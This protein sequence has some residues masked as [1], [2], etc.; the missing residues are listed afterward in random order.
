MP[1]N[2]DL[3]KM[4]VD[5]GSFRRQVFNGIRKKQPDTDFDKANMS[6]TDIE[7]QVECNCK[8]FNITDE[9]RIENV[10][11]DIISYVM[12]AKFRINLCK[13]FQIL[14]DTRH[15]FSLE[16]LYV[17]DPY[18]KGVCKLLKHESQIIHND[19][20]LIISSFKKTYCEKCKFREPLEKEVRI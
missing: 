15:S 12:A 19:P 18:R 8:T 10:R 16:T 7:M 20:E 17:V 14:Q 11:K 9:K 5:E 6:E 3:F 2:I 13:H 1:N 4:S